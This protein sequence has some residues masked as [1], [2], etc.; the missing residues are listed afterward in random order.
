MTAAAKR[1]V[2]EPG[3]AVTQN[4]CH[5]CTPLGACLAFRGIRGAV[6]FLHGSQGCSTYIRRYLISHFR[7]PIDIAA[8]NFSET[9][10]IFGGG[11]ILEQGLQNVI[12]Q[13]QPSVIGLATTCLSETIGEDLNMILHGY[14]KKHGDDEGAPAVV[15]VSTASYRGSYVDGYHDAVK[16]VVEAL[17]QGG[18]RTD[19]INLFPGIV[20][21]ADLRHVRE[22]AGLFGLDL[23]LLPDY[24]DTL[25]GPVGDDYR[26]IPE[27]G[28]SVEE[29]RA[30]GRSRMSV[31]LGRTRADMPG[32]G[33]LL[34]K[35]FGVP[36]K[37]VGLPIGIRET[38]ALMEVLCGL[39][40]RDLPPAIAA[41]RGRLIDA[42][43][44][45]HKYLAGKTVG[46]FGEPD[47]VIGFAS[48]CSEIGMRPTLCASGAKCRA[49]PAALREAVPTLPDDCAVIEDT[50]FARIEAV[51]A[52][53]KPEVLIGPSK[54]YAAARRLGIPLIRAGFPIHDRVGAQR[55]LH[56]GYRGAQQQFD[57]I[58][59]TLM[60]HRQDDSP[61]GWSYL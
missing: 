14:G 51:L 32:A 4:A 37:T 22:L 10:A 57:R 39:T 40:G 11:T 58:V 18:P 44:D 36:A 24:A 15:P 8:S 13:Y 61:V 31:Q 53:T 60:E 27:G 34:E 16:A 45:G 47:L 26:L 43:V 59:N 42:Y 9:S 20:S 49:F 23:I 48:F 25:D 52:E 28:T 5:L 30:S 54:G 56:L 38:D 2:Q 33:P 6:P 1:S 21:P 55:I 35:T 17:A 46:L 50:D 29:I 12:R 3:R 41:E 7:E 19:A